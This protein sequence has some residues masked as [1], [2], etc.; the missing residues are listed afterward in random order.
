MQLVE[1]MVAEGYKAGEKHS[2]THVHICP[3]PKKESALCVTAHLAWESFEEEL[4]LPA[5]TCVR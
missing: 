5:V 1:E 4:S 3:H 2:S